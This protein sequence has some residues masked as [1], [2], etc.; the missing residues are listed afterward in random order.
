MAQDQVTIGVVTDQKTKALLEAEAEKQD[1]S[2]SALI[3]RII[4]E[5]FKSKAM[6]RS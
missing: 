5:W 4:A 2:V 3:R 1:R 6:P